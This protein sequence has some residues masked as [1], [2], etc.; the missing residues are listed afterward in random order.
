MKDKAIE[1]QLEAVRGKLTPPMPR[2]KVRPTLRSTARASS[3]ESNMQIRLNGKERDVRDGITVADL[4]A[5]LNIHPERVAVLVNQE[6][7][8]KPSYASAILR[9]GDAVEV[10]TA[11]AGG[12]GRIR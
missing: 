2:V 8:K 10:L 1:W 5:E 9:D 11:M 12:M 4:L 7:V 6:I 3:F